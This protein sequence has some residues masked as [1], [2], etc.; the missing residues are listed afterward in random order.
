MLAEP[1]VLAT[2]ISQ[3]LH[4]H[5]ADVIESS[6]DWHRVRGADGYEGWVHEAYFESSEAS[7]PLEWG[8]E[9][10]SRMS[11]GCRVRDA[12]GTERALPLGALISKADEVVSGRALS[13]EERKIA[14]PRNADAITKTAREL[15]E[16]TFYL[17]GGITPWGC[18][19]SG[20]AQT[21]YALHGVKLRR[22]AAL[23]ATEGGEVTGGLN[24]LQPADLL[25]FSDREDGFITHVAMSLGTRRIVHLTLYQGGHAIDDLDSNDPRIRLLR[26]RFRF[27]RRVL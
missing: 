1:N 22:D 18:D 3:F 25:F 23:Q 9:S 10:R 12:K 26:G 16:G 14:H 4:G 8:W 24:G 27:A 17:W 15:F 13:L 5:Q 21:S 2:Q 6:R 7:G 11:F 19:C 20:L